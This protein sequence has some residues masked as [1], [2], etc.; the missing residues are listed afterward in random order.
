MKLSMIFAIVLMGLTAQAEVGFK[1][2]N[3]MTA[4]LSEGDITVHC[5]YGNPTMQ[6]VRCRADILTTGEYDFFVG[7]AGVAADEVTL[8]ARHQDG[9]SRTKTVDY[10]SKKGRSSKSIN[11]WI[12]T[13]LQKPL[14]DPGVNKVSYKMT[15][16]SKVAARGE[17]TAVVKDGG[18]KVCS[19]R[20]YYNDMS[21]NCM[22][23]ERYCQD[24]FRENN[25]CL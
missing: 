7:P 25:Y 24:F 5:R 4:V 14:L 8:T 23:P 13:L 3:E 1:A 18:R 21:S 6:Y 17:F 15:K 19:R 16:G 10:D 22:N 12:L 11:L 2:G 20:G 9:S